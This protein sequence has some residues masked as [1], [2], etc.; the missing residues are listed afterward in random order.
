MKQ[1]LPRLYGI[2]VWDLRPLLSCCCGYSLGLFVDLGY[3]PYVFTICIY[4][5]YQDLPIYFPYLPHGVHEFSKKF[6]PLGPWD[7]P[8][9]KAPF[10]VR[11]QNVG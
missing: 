8:S 1:K 9:Y 7:F 3:L 10:L 5:I 6:I 4:H 11:Q 2:T